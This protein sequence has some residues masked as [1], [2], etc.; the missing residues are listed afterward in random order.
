MTHFTQSISSGRQIKKRK[1]FKLLLI[2]IKRKNKR[3]KMRTHG[4]E[5]FGVQGQEV[6]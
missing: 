6:T 2:S 5:R 4:G 1:D 3:K